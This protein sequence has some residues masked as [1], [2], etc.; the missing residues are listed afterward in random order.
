MYMVM[1]MD[2]Q[3]PRIQLVFITYNRLAYTS[4]ALASILA[5]PSEFFNLTIWDN[6]STDG[7]VEYLR[8]EVNDP[9]IDDIIF[10]QKNVGQTSAINTIWGGS[11]ADLLGKLDNDCLMTPG[12][13]RNLAKVHMDIARLGVIACWHYPLDEFDEEAARRAGKIQEYGNHKILRHPWTC[14][15]G[16]LIKR[17]TFRQFGPIQ[18][19]ATTQYW[20]HMALK[21][22]VNGYYYPLVRQEHMD[23]PRSKHSLLYDDESIIKR[24]HMSVVLSNNNIRTMKEL[25]RRRRRIL[26]N[27]NSGPWEP[28]CYVGWRGKIRSLVAK[29][30]DVRAFRWKE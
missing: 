27:L 9:R 10:S 1:I 4:L 7:T 5:D 21:G 2:V 29:V 24:R 26:Y 15:T 28:R 17:E 6:A 20:L 11:K 14:G 19:K 18:G 23:D 16:L 12:W 30:R 8:K 3:S 22:Y 13:T 25:W